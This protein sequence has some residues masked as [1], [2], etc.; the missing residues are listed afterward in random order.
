MDTNHQHH[1]SHQLQHAEHEQM[2]YSTQPFETVYPSNHSITNQQDATYTNVFHPWPNPSSPQTMNHQPQ[3]NM[4][5]NHN[6]TKLDFGDS[7]GLVCSHQDPVNLWR[8]AHNTTTNNNNNNDNNHDN[9][10]H[11]QS[12]FEHAPTMAYPSYYQA[13]GNSNFEP[14]YITYYGTN[15]DLTINNHFHQAPSEHHNHNPNTDNEQHNQQTH[16]ATTT[17]YYNQYQH[18]AKSPVSQSTSTNPVN[19]Q[20]R[21]RSMSQA[22]QPP[23]STYRYPDEALNASEPVYS[24]PPIISG[25]LGLLH[26]PPSN[27]FH[28]NRPSRQAMQIYNHNSFHLQSN[29]DHFSRSPNFS[30]DSNHNNINNHDDNVKTYHSRHSTLGYTNSHATSSS[31]SMS[32]PD[33]RHESQSVVGLEPSISTN[34]T[35]VCSGASTSDVNSSDEDHGSEAANNQASTRTKNI[36]RERPIDKKCKLDKRINEGLKKSLSLKTRALTASRN[37]AATTANK[38]NICN[39]CGRNYA[40]PSTLKTHLRTHTNERPFRCEVCQKTF[41]QAANLTA[42]QRVHTGKLCSNEHE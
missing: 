7:N 15:G 30:L 42:H 31:V 29:S 28:V 3:T 17:T 10:H 39:I 24:D 32:T 21:Y 13:N 20:Q 27:H 16:N 37:Q 33:D 2:L 18:H 34:D 9:M 35:S 11:Q 19:N 4:I 23:P 40:R 8:Q 5:F 22:G 41:S 38:I 14:N 36:Y 12:P 26:A 25:E 1:F 6:P